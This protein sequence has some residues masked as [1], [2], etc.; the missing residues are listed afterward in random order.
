MKVYALFTLHEVRSNRFSGSTAPAE[1]AQ[2][3]W[4]TRAGVED[5]AEAT[6]VRLCFSHEAS[7]D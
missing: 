4:G 7:S 3:G 6:K 5:A 1:C 2:T